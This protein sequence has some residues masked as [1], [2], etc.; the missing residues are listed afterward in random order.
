MVAV[1]IWDKFDYV[2]QLCNCDFKHLMHV[3]IAI[4]W[5]NK[6][7]IHTHTHSTTITIIREKYL[8]TEAGKCNLNNFKHTYNVDSCH[9]CI[10]SHK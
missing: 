5:L 7:C 10:W 9:A 4:A 6:T 8:E 3:H 2:T 1:I